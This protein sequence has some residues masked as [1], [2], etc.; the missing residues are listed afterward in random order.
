MFLAIIPLFVTTGYLHLISHR[1]YTFGNLTDVCTGC[2]FLFLFRN[3]ASAI[4]RPFTVRY[5]PYTESISLIN[6]KKQIINLAA[7]VKGN[8]VSL[9][10]LLL[11]SQ[12][13]LLVIHETDWM[14]NDSL[15]YDHHKGKIT[16]YISNVLRINLTAW[17]SS[18]SDITCRAHA[19]V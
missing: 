6:N 13:F 19:H 10:C 2:C 18:G 16:H 11:Y 7:S 5:N 15:L 4:L 9:G 17:F 8:H 14:S 12:T 1:G 3:Y